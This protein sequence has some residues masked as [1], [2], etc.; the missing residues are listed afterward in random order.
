M[1]IRIN[2]LKQIIKEEIQA[3][4]EE[5]R[6]KPRGLFRKIFRMDHPKVDAIIK[7]FADDV[8]KLQAEFYDVGGYGSRS[9]DAYTDL[10]VRLGEAHSNYLNSMQAASNFDASKDQ[11]AR[12]KQIKKSFNRQT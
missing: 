3:V 4:L 5:Q 12:S 9:N 10:L 8:S 11:R 6:G 7:R 2:E 1:K